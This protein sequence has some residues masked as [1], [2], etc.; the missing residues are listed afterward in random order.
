MTMKVTILGSG[1]SSGVPLIGC[2]CEVCTSTDPKN[3][4]TRA[5]AVVEVNGKVF[6]LDTSTDLREQA[7]RFGLLRVDAVLYTHAHADHVHGIDELRIFN[8]R[9]LHEIPCYANK[10]TARRLRAYFEYIFEMAES[11]SIR[12]FLTIYEIEKEFEIEGQKVI[13]IPAWHGQTQV[14]GYRIDNFAYL[15]D[16]NRIP[17]ASLEMLRDL[18]LLV[19]DAL[20]LKPHPTHFGLEEALQVI[21]QLKPRRAVLTHIAH[22]IDHQI[23]SRSLPQNVELAYDGMVCS[24]PKE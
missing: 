11:E 16:V 14:F 12:P 3:N 18:D 20:R 4:R 21:E 9:H 17:E 6:L 8:I 15:T 23:I 10:D 7:I 5:S 19:L 1:T 24:V 13:P 22:Q 2:T